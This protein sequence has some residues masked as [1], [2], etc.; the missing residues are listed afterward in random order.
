MTH[1][2]DASSQAN[3]LARSLAQCLDKRATNGLLRTIAPR[4]RDL[5]DFCSNDYLG[6]ARST[7]LAQEIDNQAKRAK[8]NYED[9]TS[10]STGSRLLT[11]TNH[12]YEHVEKCMK[13][14]Y[15]GPAAL[16]FNSGYDLNLGLFASVPQKGDIVLYDELMHNSVREGL[17]LSRGKSKSFAHN[18][19]KDLSSI[20]NDLRN[21]GFEGNIIVSV[22][23][24]YSM[25]G[26]V[27]PLCEL[28]DLCNLHNASLIVDEAHGVGVFGRGGRGYVDQLGLNDQVFCRVVTFGKAPGV[29]GAAMI[30]P[31]VLREYLVNYCR[32]LIYST[33]LPSHSL[34][35]IMASHN[36]MERFATERQMHLRKLINRFCECLQMYPSLSAKSLVSTS[37][38][39]GVIIP[40]NEVVSRLACGLCASGFDVMPI[41]SPTVPVG[42]ERIRVIIHYH[43]TI[44]Q[45]EDLVAKMDNLLSC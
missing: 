18:D 12:Y 4:N 27:A 34:T 5:I 8:I 31:K 9:T 24:V 32:P 16:L 3:P 17:K 10:G 35:A 45:V 11:G 1:F 39:Q 40:G 43:N 2:Q 42:T 33:S 22:E 6:F 30:G 13:E 21:N 37:A 20:L 23:S 41:R 7:I 25:D 14:Y 29:H 28:V 44:T 36:I 26:H 38:I 15:N 19:T